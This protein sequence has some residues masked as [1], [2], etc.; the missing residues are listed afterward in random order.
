MKR[1]GDNCME[2]EFSPFLSVV[3]SYH[4]IVGPVIFP[5]DEDP[6]KGASDLSEIAGFVSAFVAWNRPPDLHVFS[7]Y[8]ESLRSHSLLLAVS[9][10]G[11]SVVRVS[12]VDLALSVLSSLEAVVIEAEDLK[13]LAE[14]GLPFLSFGE[15]IQLNDVV[16]LVSLTPATRDGTDASEGPSDVLFLLEGQIPLPGP[17]LQPVI[18][19]SR[20]SRLSEVV[21]A[22]IFRL[23]SVPTTVAQSSPRAGGREPEK[24]V[25]LPTS[26]CPP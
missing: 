21:T 13:V 18:L 9:G 1:P 26:T 12:N 5:S 10:R 14:I 7:L 4:S 19:T 22:L 16:N 8:V 11:A 2:E 25:Q 15:L 3:K 17:L 6:S 23:L 20:P 24:E